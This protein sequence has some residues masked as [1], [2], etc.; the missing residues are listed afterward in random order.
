MLLID[1]SVL[2]DEADEGWIMGVVESSG[3]KGLF[4]ENFTKLL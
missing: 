4:P 3:R 1:L 2:Q